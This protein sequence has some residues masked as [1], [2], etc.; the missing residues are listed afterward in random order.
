MDSLE[1]SV[2]ALE[3]KSLFYNKSISVYV[4]GKDDVLFWQYLFNIAE[5]SAHIEEVGGDS[6]IE[7]YIV[8]ILDN[9][10]GF[11]VAYDNDHNEFMD[12]SVEHPRLI[13]TYGYSIENSMYNFKQIENVVSKLCRES[14]D[15]MSIIEEWAEEFTNNVYD[16]LRY[17]IANHKFKKGIQVF[18]DNCVRFLTS[19]SSHKISSE[20]VNKFIEKISDK[21]SEEEMLKVDY[22]LS[23]SKKEFWFLIKGHFLTNATMN[24][25]KSL[26]RKMSGG[27]CAI[28][29][30]MIYALTIDCTESW[31]DRIDIFTVISE[32][33]KL[34]NS[35]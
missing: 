9:N 10:A 20:K 15:V 32:I 2:D 18:G 22:L 23:V 12:N 16:L 19:N 1:Y 26:V 5:I 8:E 29:L 30:D 17:D 24:L 34:K 31:E 33:R 27:S 3:A 13:R 14:V 28:S 4:E 21:F 11:V 25:I 7:K 6:E 35:A